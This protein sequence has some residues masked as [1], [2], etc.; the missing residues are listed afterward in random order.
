MQFLEI[1]FLVKYLTK[2]Q[3]LYKSKLPLFHIFLGWHEFNFL[4]T[5]IYV[6]KANITDI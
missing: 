1:T 5:Y 3:N 4:R 2:N 6:N